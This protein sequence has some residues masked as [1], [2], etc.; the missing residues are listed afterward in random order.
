MS[1]AS[2]FDSQPSATPLQATSRFDS[3][4]DVYG[5]SLK[6]EFDARQKTITLI[7]RSPASPAARALAINLARFQ[8]HSVE[9][10]VIFAQIAPADAFDAFVRAMSAA[11]QQ[12]PELAIRWIKDRALLDAHERLTLG[13]SL[14]WT[15]DSM[16]RAEDARGGIDRV[17]DSTPAMLSEAHASFARMWRASKPIPKTLFSRQGGLAVERIAPDAS[18]LDPSYAVK[19][20]IVRLDDYLRLRRH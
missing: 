20:N 3:F 8:P 16:R 5:L 17:E 15:G 13:A 18:P 11:R 6:H 12:G 9:V 2:E 19:A 7:A 1:F 10:T 4:F 14:C